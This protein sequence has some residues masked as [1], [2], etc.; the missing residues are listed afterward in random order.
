MAEPLTVEIDIETLG[1]QGDGIGR[2]EGAQVF[3]PY[4]LPGDRV[5]VR[6]E[7][8]GKGAFT[9]R[10]AEI[11]TQSPA[12]V[13]PPCPLFTRCGG[14]ALQ[15]LAMPDYL[16]WKKAQVAATL[17]TRA[18][19]LPA[20]TEIMAMQPGTRRRAVFAAT[21]DKDRVTLG[22]HAVMSHEIVPLDDCLLLTPAL[23]AA[24]PHLARLAAAA[25]NNKQSA[26]CQVTETLSGL[27]ILI[28]S[29]DNLAETRRQPL[30]AAARAA[31]IARISWAH[32]KRQP[33]PIFM[34][35]VPQVHFAGILVDLPIGAFLQPSAE[36][37]A[38]LVAAVTEGVG[39]AKRVADLYG[40]CGTF[41]FPLALMARVLSVDSAKPAVAALIAAVNRAQLSGRV[42]GLARDLDQSPLPPQD[43]KAYDAVVFDPPRAGAEMQARMLAKSIVKRVIAVSCNPASF[44]RDARILLDAGFAME[45]LTILDQFLWSHHTELVAIFARR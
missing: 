14:C 15:H 29:G 24:L 26:D 44:A 31:D 3:V 33:E 37:E 45:K 17:A 8:K 32:G 6:L 20:G 43:L 25:L 13:V 16:A 28:Q 21:K 38:A 12:R 39:K 34:E 35:R 41:S 7:A 2:H 11:V 23:R 1:A 5:R 18:I 19:A 40:G 27:D 42:E 4:A 10:L 30:I 9:G 36:G 22:F